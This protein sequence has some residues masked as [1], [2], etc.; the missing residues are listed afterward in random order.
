MNVDVVNNQNEKVGT[1]ELSDEL[2]GGEIA[3]H[4]VWES[5]VHANAAERRGTH[6][7]K[8]RGLVSGT[9]KKPWRQKGTG[10]ARV[11]ESRNPLWRKGGTVFGPQPRSYD[12]RRA[13]E[14]RAGRAARGAGGQAGRRRRWSSSRRSPPR[15]PRRRRPP[16]CCGA[17]ASTARAC[18]VDVKAD[19]QAGPRRA[20]PRGRPAGRERPA[21]GA[22]PGGRRPRGGDARGGRAAAGSAGVTES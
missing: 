7:T 3:G 4:L 5:V 12:Y 19:E 10:R 1:L 11:G 13:A 16:R 2:F 14:G 8:T 15:R 18:I 20:Q 22:R 9:G 17:S 6:A 21:H